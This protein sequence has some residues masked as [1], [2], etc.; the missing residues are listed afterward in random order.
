MVDGFVSARKEQK[1][2]VILSLTVLHIQLCPLMEDGVSGVHGEDVL[3]R[4]VQV[5]DA[6]I[7]RVLDQFPKMEASLVRDVRRM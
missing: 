4:V 7:V 6:D 1:S 3:L 5:S 2:T